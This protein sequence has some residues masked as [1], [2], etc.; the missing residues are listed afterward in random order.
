MV[1]IIARIFGSWK[2]PVI[3]RAV[4]GMARVWPGRWRGPVPAV[5]PGVRVVAPGSRVDFACTFTRQA[6]WACARC[7][8]VTV[9]IVAGGAGTCTPRAIPG[10][11]S[12]PGRPRTGGRGRAK[13]SRTRPGDQ[14][15]SAAQM[16]ERGSVGIDVRVRLRFGAGTTPGA[17]V[18]GCQEQS[19]RPGN[20]VRPAQ[21]IT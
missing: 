2:L 17:V 10:S 21:R 1:K 3:A 14:P 8:E 19:D 20:S 15:G 6:L 9:T 16:P 4:R 12:W 7:A 11:E 18:P 13:G 5:L